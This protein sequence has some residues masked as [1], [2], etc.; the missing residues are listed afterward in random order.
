MIGK[1]SKARLARKTELENNPDP[2][3]PQLTNWLSPSAENIAWLAEQIAISKLPG[4]GARKVIEE[5]IN[6]KKTGRIALARKI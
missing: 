4:H 6:G 1:T 3:D 5:K 2:S